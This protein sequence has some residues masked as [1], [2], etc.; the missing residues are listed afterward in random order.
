MSDSLQPHGLWPARILCPGDLPWPRDQ[1]HVSCL[2]GKFATIEPHGKPKSKILLPKYYYSRPFFLF[3]IYQGIVA[4]QATDG[5]AV[6]NPPANAGDAGDMDL[7][8][9]SRSPAEGHDNLL[10]Y[11]F[12]KNSMDRGAWRA[13]IHGV[14]KNLTRLNS[15]ACTHNLYTCKLQYKKERTHNSI[16]MLISFYDGE[17]IN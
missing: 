12:L 7:I 16:V 3:L 14:A 8:P 9:G 5:S 15:W 13:A 1:I 11:S 2:A 10:Q 4:L 17:G 6:K